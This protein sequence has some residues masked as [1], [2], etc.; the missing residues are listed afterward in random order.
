MVVL[1]AVAAATAALGVAEAVE[2]EEEEAAAAGMSSNRGG[3]SPLVTLADKEADA[4]EGDKA[5]LVALEAAG[6]GE[7][8]AGAAGVAGAQSSMDW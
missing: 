4:V 1:E 8:P 7:A 5:S 2:E 3:K 6:G